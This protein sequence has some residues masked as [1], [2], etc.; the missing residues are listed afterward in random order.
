MLVIFTLLGDQHELTK[1]F[2]TSMRE[3]LH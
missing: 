3:I 2:Q 1:S